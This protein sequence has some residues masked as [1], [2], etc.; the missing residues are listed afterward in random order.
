MPLKIPSFVRTARTSSRRT[1]SDTPAR[2]ESLEERRLFAVTLVSG[3]G[4]VGQAASEGALEPSVSADGN[5]VA[6][7][8]DATNLGPVDTNGARDV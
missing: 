2:F 7:S 3:G 1:P 8:S 6:F 4:A 5:L